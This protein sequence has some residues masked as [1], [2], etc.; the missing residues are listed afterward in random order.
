MGD[1]I[2]TTSFLP[3]VPLFLMAGG[4]MVLVIGALLLQ[5]ATRVHMREQR[6]DRLRTQVGRVEARWHEAA[7]Q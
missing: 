2:L 1:E 4:V 6:Q 3:S 5:K 7:T